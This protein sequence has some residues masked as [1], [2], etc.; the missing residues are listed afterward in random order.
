MIL[1]PYEESYAQKWDDF[2]QNCPM[3]TFLHTRKFL[4]YHRDRFQDKSYIII[5]EN[6]K[7]L[8]LFPAAISP[9]NSKQI[10][11]HPGITYGGV[12]HE[13]KLFG[14]DMIEALKSLAE[15]YKSSGFEELIYKATPS[16]YHESPS[17]D[18]LYALFVL[19]AQLY[20]RDLSCTISLSIPTILSNKAQSKMR[21]MLRKAENQGVTIND[22][23]DYEQFSQFLKILEN[24]L[25]QKYGTKPVH[26]LEEIVEIQSRFPDTIKIITACLNDKV[27]AGAVLFL[28]RKTMH[29]QYLA[30]TKA[31][32]EIFALDYVIQTCINKARGDGFYYFDF[33]INTENNGRVLND[34][35]YSSKLKHGGSGTVHDFYSL[36]LV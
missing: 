32:K 33:G 20:R 3:A 26:T 35:L 18:D 1:T 4:S 16:F 13:G 36:R 24:N 23:Q 25:K 10:V 8:G 17:S 31:G 21:N 2:T 5:D 28:K 7:W 22:S 11:S 30:A 14:S 9:S 19:N 6:G 15:T 29:T 34:G 12:L 27:V